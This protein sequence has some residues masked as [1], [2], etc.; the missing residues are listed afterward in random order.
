MKKSEKVKCTPLKNIH[1]QMKKNKQRREV[2]FEVGFV[3]DDL[4][5]PH[6]KYLG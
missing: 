5:E 1:N 4:D 3:F 6:I 2:P